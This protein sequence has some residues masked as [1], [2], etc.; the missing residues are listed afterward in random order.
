MIPRIQVSSTLR[1]KYGVNSSLSNIQHEST[2]NSTQMWKLCCKSSN[3]FKKQV[4]RIPGNGKR[5]SI[6]KD[7]IM[8]RE[9]LV[10]NAEIADL[11]EWLERAGVNRVYDLSKWDHRG[12]WAG[13]D[14]HG[15]PPRLDQQQ[16]ILVDLLE[17]AAPANRAIKDR[18]G[19]GQSGIYTSAAGY[20]A[21][22]ASKNSSH[23]PA[24]WKRVWDQLSIPKV[25]FFFWTLM[26]NKILT[27]DN[28]EKRNI[29]GPHR[30]ALC[31][32][33][34]ETSQHL[35]MG[36]TFAKEVWGLFLQD[37]HIIIPPQNSVAELF[38]SWNLV[39]PQRIPSKSFWTKIWT[40][41]PK[42]VCWQIWLARNQKIFKEEKQSPLQVAAKAKSFL[43]EAAQ[44]QYLNRGSLCYFQRKRGG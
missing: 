32:N 35:F 30:C 20:R 34:S 18:W 26:H 17:D 27:G 7:S 42:Y 43:L 13:W 8:G 37:F 36:C 39:Y 38:A 11:R 16:S 40:A 10:E 41:I 6:W 29:A 31:N 14:F 28:L 12:D 33:N 3:F 5:T 24:F 21:L 23:P 4:Y 22:Q 2:A 19:W 9:P 25:N 44:Q 15:V 1:A